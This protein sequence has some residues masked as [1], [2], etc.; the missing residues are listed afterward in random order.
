[1][2]EKTTGADGFNN[3]LSQGREHFLKAAAATYDRYVK[4]NGIAPVGTGIV[5]VGADGSAKA[6]WLTTQEMED[7]SPLLAKSAAFSFSTSVASLDASGGKFDIT[8]WNKEGETSFYGDKAEGGEGFIEK[9]K[10]TLTG[11]N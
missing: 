10:E 6:D 8:S 1:M 4:N 7:M 9:A 2:N 11:N 3:E 5:Q